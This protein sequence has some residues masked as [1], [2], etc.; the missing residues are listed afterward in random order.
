MAL[1]VFGPP[2]TRRAY[3]SVMR[4]VA[5]ALGTRPFAGDEAELV[6]MF[7]ALEG[8]AGCHGFDEPL[9]FSD[10]LGPNEPWVDSEAAIAEILKGLTTES[11]RLEAVHA[12]LLVSLFADDPDPEA[13]AAAIEYWKQNKP[14][15]L[16]V[17]LDDVDHAGQQI[18]RRMGVERGA[19]IGDAY[20][21]MAITPGI[22]Q[23]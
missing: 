20:A 11:D 2:E 8:C 5:T 23:R 10:L 6:T 16:W 15:L 12:G 17:H 3:I 14:L 13:T 9:D 4:L 21:V 19:D 18:G 7:A 1:L 22:G